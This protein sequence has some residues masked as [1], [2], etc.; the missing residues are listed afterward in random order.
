MAKGALVIANLP[1]FAG[2]VASEDALAV[3][4]T[5]IVAAE[6]AEAIGL[7]SAVTVAAVGELGRLNDLTVD[8]G[9]LRFRLLVITQ[10]INA[11]FSAIRAVRSGYP[12]IATRLARL[13]R[14]SQLACIWATVCPQEA[15]ACWGANLTNGV[16]SWPRAGAMWKE[17]EPKL[18][19][20]DPA[21]IT[22]IDGLL[23][24]YM[25]THNELFA[26][27]VS[28]FSLL[29]HVAAG[30]GHEFRPIIGP[31]YDADLTRIVIDHFIP[32]ASFVL[33][34]A[35]MLSRAAGAGDMTSDG[36]E[37]LERALAWWNAHPIPMIEV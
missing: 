1:E 22:K 28:D 19:E 5:K 11:S 6:H 8:D 14:E 15:V 33:N 3:A 24:R 23:S 27:A 29:N 21:L 7:W 36:D 37:V 12:M 9:A 2:V 30:D 35:A 13:L 32:L 10:S 34:D 17:V 25:R 4:A 16:G 20:E 26:H 31:A 18:K